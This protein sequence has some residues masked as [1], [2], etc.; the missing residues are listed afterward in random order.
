MGRSDAI[1]AVF[2]HRGRGSMRF[3]EWVGL[4]CLTIAVSQMPAKL[5]STLNSKVRECKH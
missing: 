5:F 1:T 2:A 3:R 4:R